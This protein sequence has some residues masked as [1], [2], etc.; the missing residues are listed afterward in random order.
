MRDETSYRNIWR[1]A[2]PIIVGSISQTVLNITD[3]IFVGHL[4]ELE[5]GAGA[6][7]TLFYLTIMMV[8][9]GFT[10]GNQ[11]IMARRFGEER[12]TD[13]GRTF[14]S[15]ILVL[16]TITTAVFLAIKLL[17]STL[18]PTLVSNAQISQLVDGF[19]QYRIWGIYAAAF[20]LLFR[21]F[22]VATANTKVL[23]PVTTT[24][25]GLNIILNY[26]LIYG[27]FGFPAMG[28]NGA[29]LASV[30][31]EVTGFAII[32][33]YTI[34]KKYPRAFGL[35]NIRRFEPQIAGETLKIASPVMLQHLISFS[36][37]FVIFLIIERMGER[38]LAISNIVRS[39][40]IAMMVPIWGFAEATN[41][42]VSYLMG[43]KHF[44]RIAML[45]KRSMLLSFTSVILVVAAFYLLLPQIIGFYSP[46]TSLVADTIP[47]A[48]VVMIGAT[49]MSLGFIV[50][51]AVSGTGNTLTAFG[52]ELSDITLYI[53]IA[54]V[55]V[56]YAHIN[57]T[58]IW[59]VETFYAGYMLIV[60]S[61]YLRLGK[62]RNKVI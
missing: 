29:A 49:I 52:L 14:A 41:S 6:L 11:I 47:V 37:W 9:T 55:L 3:T 4:G 48:K 39:L 8:I 16:F 43:E 15:S 44:D 17:S 34:Y 30:I 54:F 12:T 51:M 38:S 20:T 27:K 24:T 31:S 23:I 35:F 10:I 60:C 62:W 28:F 1:I 36:A 46:D 21:S 59:F 42:L 7:G 26:V 61:L 19:I 57:V 32:L 58:N 33:A 56:E 22:Y 18:L 25:V 2:Y 50:F 13:I 45:V 5:L 53:I 40:Y